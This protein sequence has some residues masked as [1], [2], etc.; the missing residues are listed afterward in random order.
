[1]VILV[2]KTPSYPAA[3]LPITTSTSLYVGLWCISINCG[4]VPRVPHSSEQPTVCIHHHSFNKQIL[5]NLTSELRVHSVG[6]VHVLVCGWNWSEKLG[7]LSWK[8]QRFLCLMFWWFT[9]FPVI[10]LPACIFPVQIK[11]VCQYCK[12]MVGNNI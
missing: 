3:N 2:C 8:T 5:E 4:A 7:T 1:M 11:S 6:S 12:I 9:S 10:V